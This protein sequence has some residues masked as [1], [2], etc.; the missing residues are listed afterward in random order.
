MSKGIAYK[1]DAYLRRWVNGVLSRRIIGPVGS[2]KLTLKPNAEIKERLGK[3]RDNFGLV[4]GSITTNQPTD[5]AL[6]F[7][8]VD[9]EVLAMLFMGEA[10]ALNEAG[11]SVTGENITLV[12]DVWVK[13]DHRNISAS[14][15]AA[16]TPGVDFIEHPRMGAIMAKTPGAVGAQ[17]LDYTYAGITG[18]RVSS[19]VGDKIEV[20]IIFD[21]N[22]LEDGS[23]A[24]VRIPKTTLVPNADID[25]LA[26]DY[27]DAEMSG[28]AIKMPNETGDVIFDDGVVYA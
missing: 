19:G 3:G 2:T 4:V 13:T 5:V 8:E 26:G 17:S 25:L 11:G 9:P 22:N 18:T 1:G 24:Y 7:N 15:I 12:Q 14:V 23:D 6:S 27:I 20:E 21:G 28:K 16:L 10:A